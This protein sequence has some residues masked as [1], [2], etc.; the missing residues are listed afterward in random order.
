MNEP[1]A[2]VALS[3]VEREQAFTRFQ[4]LQPFLEG[5]TSLTA[6]AQNQ[7]VTLRTL[8]RWV[9]RYRATGL[10]GLARQRRT[11]RGQRQ[12]EPVVQRLIEGLALQK[13]KPSAAA[14]HRQVA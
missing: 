5:Q 6:L 7:T 8:Q 9:T 13:T 3:P 1:P 4:I 12:L 10:V 2:L 14:I 11:D